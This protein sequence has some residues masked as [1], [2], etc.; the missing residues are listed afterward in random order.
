MRYDVLVVNEQVAYPRSDRRTKKPL[1]K[2]ERI[3]TV[4]T[5]L[6]VAGTLIAI[7]PPIFMPA[8]VNSFRTACLGNLKRISTAALVY[9]ADNNDQLPAI[10]GRTNSGTSSL[11]TYEDLIE[12]YG[13]DKSLEFSC[14]SDLKRKSPITGKSFF[15]AQ[16]S[17]YRFLP[18]P[19]QLSAFGK[20]NGAS[21]TVFVRDAEAFHLFEGDGYRL[22][23]L[24][25][26]G[27][28]K[29]I[30]AAKKTSSL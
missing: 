10:V 16:G 29:T 1:S 11:P 25:Y 9:A 13:G 27:H 6:T 18:D 23:V 15:E 3:A 2:G 7:L 22:N 30:H 28:V 21:T 19:V 24:Y 14:P 17:S 8:H 4:F 20:A 5:C 12:E 26:D